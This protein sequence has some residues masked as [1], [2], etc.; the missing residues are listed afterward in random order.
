MKKELIEP[1]KEKYPL[2]YAMYEYAQ[3]FLIA[4][5]AAEDMAAMDRSWSLVKRIKLECVMR[6]YG[7]VKNQF[8]TGN[9]NSCE[10]EWVLE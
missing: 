5:H 8:Y 7:F 9:P 1:D 4:Y 2:A 3:D 10:I 6:E